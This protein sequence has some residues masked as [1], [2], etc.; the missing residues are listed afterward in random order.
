MPHVK[1][2]VRVPDELKSKIDA[3]VKQRKAERPG[4]S[5]NKLVIE[6]L[7]LRLKQDA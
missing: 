5:V 4:Y 2:T 1:F 3:V 7:K 6:A